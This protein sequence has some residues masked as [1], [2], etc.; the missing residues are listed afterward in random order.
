MSTT[1][2]TSTSVSVHACSC[3]RICSLEEASSHGHGDDSMA[4]H[5]GH[6]MANSATATM[7]DHDMAD[8]HAEHKG[9]GAGDKHADHGP[10]HNGHETMFRKRFFI[11]TALSVPVLFWSQTIQGWFNYSAPEFPGSELIVP[12]IATFVFI[13]GGFPFL[14]MAT[15]ELRKRQPAMMTLIS[16]AI[17]VAYGF[18]MLTV[19]LPSIGE[20]FFWELVTLIDIMLFGHWMEMK[21]VRQASGALGALA[22]LMPDTADVEAPDGTV[23]TIPAS[24]LDQGQ[25]ILIRPGASVPADGIIIDGESDFDEALITGESR[26]VKKGVDA[27]V[28]AGTV[29]SGAGAVRAKV[30]ATGDDTAL[31][32]I[33]KLVAAA[34]ASKSPTQLLADRAATFLFYAAVIAAAL[35]ALVWTLIYG[36]FD[37][38]TIARVVT[39]LVIAC[40]HALGLAIPLVV[41][42]TTAVA[43]ENGILISKRAAIDTARNLNVVVFDKTGTLTTGQMGVAEMATVEGVTPERALALAAAVEGDSEHPMARAIRTSADERGIDVPAPESF[44]ALKGRG[45]R[46]T[47]DGSDVFVGG[48]RLIESLKLELPQIL[49]E[50]SNVAGS[51]GESVVYVIDGTTPIGAIAI[52]DIIRPESYTALNALEERGIKV[53][54]ITGDSDDVARAVA[55]DLGIDIVFSQVLPADKDAYVSQLQEKGDNVGM[56]GDGVNDAPALTRADIGIAIGSG[57]DVAVQAADLVL[58][59]SDPRDVVKIVRLSAASMRKQLQNIWWG[60]G[61]NIVMVPLAMGIAVPLGFDMPPALGAVF[62]SLSTI[63]VAI[64]AQTLRRVN[65]EVD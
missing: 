27:T 64:N 43:A 39:V 54:M 56:V 53:G 37:E 61:Y 34:E 33:M 1:T 51:R 19:F 62:M 6:A 15:F 60:A 48:P 31:S 24:E 45:V 29:N 50:F 49:A 59:K 32:G 12:V 10:D 35:T 5:D 44:E 65:I 20:D 2:D 4:G 40:P 55:E 18:S 36:G 42:N 58:V 9:H 7:T 8:E 11:A 57:T 21:S 41:S 28:I 3:C 63:I 26:P 17:T 16:L 38:R 13:Y 52:S 23:T 47:I 14:S 25:T 30:T 46:A 22:K